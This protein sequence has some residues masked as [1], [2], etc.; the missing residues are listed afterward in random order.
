MGNLTFF[1]SP[2]ILGTNESKT[3]RYF[4]LSTSVLN[5]PNGAIFFDIKVLSK[6]E[7]IPYEDLSFTTNY[8]PSGTS[9]SPGMVPSGGGQNP[10]PSHG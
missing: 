5:R 7:G 9:K 1:H 10:L 6:E 3:I 4:R 8:Q 2:P